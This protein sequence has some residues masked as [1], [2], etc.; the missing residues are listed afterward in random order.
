MGAES[1]I[2]DVVAGRFVMAES[3][4]AFDCPIRAITIAKSLDGREEALVRGLDLGRA[5]A[6]VS[7]QYTHQAMGARVARNLGAVTE[8]VLES[9]QADQASADL[10]ASRTRHAD[11]LIAVGSGTLNDLCKHVSHR[12]G[13]PYAVFATA[14]SMNGYTTATASISCAGQKHSLPAG[15]PRGVFFDLDVLAGAPSRMIR[16]GIG[17]ALCRSTAQVDWLL[18]HLLRATPYLTSPFQIQAAAEPALIDGAAGAVAGDRQA[19]GALVHLLVLG[20]LGMLLAGSSQPGSQG[21]HLISHYLDMF[22]TP[23]PGSLHGEQ[24]GVATLTMAR[25]QHQILTEQHPPEIR[26]TR[27]DPHDMQHRF[28]PLYEGCIRALQKKAVDVAAADALNTRLEREWPEIRRRLLD[29][30]VPLPRLEAALEAAGVAT[31]P[32]DIGVAPDFYRGAVRH[33]RKIRDRFT[34][35]DLAADA[36]RLEDFVDA[37]I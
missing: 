23:H 35:L 11:A 26:P 31:R 19:L 4:C 15:P 7:D 13:K 24:V 25:L 12:R 16:A 5:L 21:E 3:G 36:G 32:E 6:V 33:A 17:D 2:A 18:S 8:I 29:V 1:I 14:P 30:M 37:E 9:P 10:L 34:M 27:I 28:G 22:L 20:G